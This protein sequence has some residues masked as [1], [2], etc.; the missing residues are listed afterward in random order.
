MDLDLVDLFSGAGGWEVGAAALGKA[1]VGID[2]DPDVVATRVAEELDTLEGDVRMFHAA[3]F[4]GVD[5]LLASPPCQSLSLVGKQV[6][7]REVGQVVDAVRSGSLLSTSDLRTGLM[8]YPLDWA[9]RMKPRAIAWEQV[10]GALPIWQ[11]C[12]EVLA[13]NGYSVWTGILDA[14]MYG[15]PQ[16]RRRAILMAALDRDVEPP[17]PTHSRYHVRTPDKLDLWVPS[18]RSIKDVLDVGPF[19]LMGDVR[20]SRGTIRPVDRPA[21]TVVASTDNG[22]YRWVDG[23][24]QQVVMPWEF[25]VLQTFPSDYEWQGSMSAQFRQVGNAIPPL[26]AEAILGALV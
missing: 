17:R 15:V 22:N 20:T 21:G 18:W 6:G 26:L 5:L 12:G 9:L 2:N 7:L 11:A 4:C 24:R 23:D 1:G 8:T 25:G 16:T 10:P 13:E 19:E 14:E 3:D